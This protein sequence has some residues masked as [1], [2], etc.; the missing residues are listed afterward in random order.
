MEGIN[1]LVKVGFVKERPDPDD[2]RAKLVSITDKGM[3]KLRGCFRNAQ[4][5]NEMIFRHLPN[6]TVDFCVQLL[7]STEEIHSRRS[8]EL[9]QKPFDEMYQEMMKD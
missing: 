5:V 9:K 1:K 8:V 3:R 4:K 2:G 7:Q 6:D